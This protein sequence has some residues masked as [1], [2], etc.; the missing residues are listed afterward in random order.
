V[1][2]RLYQAVAE[3]DLDAALDCFSEDAVW[4][5]PGRSAIAGEHRGRAAIRDD[6]LSKVGPLSGGTFKAGLV[7]VAVGDAHV[8]AVQHATA[9]F[10]GKV[11]DITACQLIRVAD[12]KIV[13]IRG[14]YSDQYA[15]DDFWS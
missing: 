2:R 9:E 14:H 6:F 3:R 12:G 4:V 1:V 7:E 13:E 5:L 15:L 10:R 8:V 11:L